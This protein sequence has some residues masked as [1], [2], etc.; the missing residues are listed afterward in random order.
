MICLI[1]QRAQQSRKSNVFGVLGDE[2][3]RCEEDPGVDVLPTAST[4]NY[5]QTGAP[6]IS[7]V[8]GEALI[9][10]HAGHVDR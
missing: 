6:E 10:Y 5:S 3:L 4:E 7:N 2:R 1:G 9:S 8:A